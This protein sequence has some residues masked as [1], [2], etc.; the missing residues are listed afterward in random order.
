MK[1]D[2]SGHVL[3]LE[4]KPI[5]VQMETGTSEPLTLERVAVSSLLQ[6]SDKLSGDE[7]YSRYTLMRKIHHKRAPVDLR[8]EDIATLKKVIGE[9]QY[10]PLVTGQAWDLLEGKGNVE[11]AKDEADGNAEGEGGGKEWQTQE[12]SSTDPPD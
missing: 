1:V 9:S 4:D 12:S 11:A 6:M 5:L 8:A 10:T 3:D 2:F 7:K